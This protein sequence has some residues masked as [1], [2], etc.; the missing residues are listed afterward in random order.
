MRLHFIRND[1]QLLQA[2]NP[3]F[4]G[5]DAHKPGHH[6]IHRITTQK[7]FFFVYSNPSQQAKAHCHT[8][9]AVQATV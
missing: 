7:M 4:V 8:Q 5:M 3:H 2:Y 9:E 1:G 6:G